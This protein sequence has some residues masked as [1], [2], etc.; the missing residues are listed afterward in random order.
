MNHFIELHGRVLN[1]T[2]CPTIPVCEYVVTD[3]SYVCGFDNFL[4]H[5]STCVDAI[6]R[7]RREG[8]IAEIPNNQHG[9]HFGIMRFD[10]KLNDGDT[11]A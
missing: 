1:Y 10:N 2:I 3:V 4:N 5:V 9:E 8:Y 7:S 6:F 11:L